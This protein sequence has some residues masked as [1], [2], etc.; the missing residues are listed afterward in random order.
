V[1]CIFQENNDYA[2]ELQNLYLKRY[3]RKFASKPG[4]VKTLARR[5]FSTA[6][7]VLN[8][9]KDVSF[10]TLTSSIY[11]YCKESHLKWLTREYEGQVEL[12]GANPERFVFQLHKFYNDISFKIRKQ[13]LYTEITEFLG[14]YV[15]LMYT[16]STGVNQAVIH[17]Y[18]NLLIQ[19]MEYLR[20]NKF[21]FTKA[22]IGATTSGQPMYGDQLY[23]FSDT[24]TLELEELMDHNAASLD[25]LFGT[26][27]ELYRQQGIIISSPEDMLELNQV[28]LVQENTT[29]ALLP[30]VNEY[31][32]DICPQQHYSSMVAPLLDM[33]VT[34]SLSDIQK[35]L[36]MRKR[37][38]PSNGSRV[39]F[40]DQTGELKELLL[41]EIVKNNTVIMLYRLTTRHGDVSGYYNTQTDFLYSVT[42]DVLSS[43]KPYQNIQS[44]LLYCYALCVNN[45]FKSNEI[46]ICN[47]KTPVFITVF[48][49]EGKLKE[50]YLNETHSA[51]CRKD[52]PD[53][54]TQIKPLNGYVRKLPVGQSASPEA[55]A[56]AKQMGYDLD[57]DETYVRP[58]CKTI[59][60]KNDKAQ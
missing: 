15:E 26:M 53:Y 25:D 41:K 36:K 29:V 4:P 19:T 18:S 37:T 50:V 42:L 38:L 51:S 57:P 3:K 14:A 16:H 49:T 2:T 44:V 35:S 52:N 46:I 39:I 34:I 43:H 5:T 23:P 9:L 30:Y 17:A 13:S 40:N 47:K 6:L 27:V 32:C 31:T 45:R 28:L 59:F 7:S 33:V 58:F 60:I 12:A 24:P 8:N 48:N 54:T 1:I 22:L 11:I 55:I 10:H 56:M 21:D 20:P